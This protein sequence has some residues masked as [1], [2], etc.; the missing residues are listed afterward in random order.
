MRHSA[1]RLGGRI[2]YLDADTAARVNQLRLTD[3]AAAMALADRGGRAQ[4]PDGG[5]VSIGLHFLDQQ[6]TEP[7]TQKTIVVDGETITTDTRTANMIEGLQGRLAVLDTLTS[8]R[9]SNA[10]VLDAAGSAQQAMHLDAVARRDPATPYGAY[11]K[12]LADAWKNADV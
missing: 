3:F 10:P 5:S 12:R 11:A 8:G 6:R 9:T 2:Y 7:M 1:F 4:V